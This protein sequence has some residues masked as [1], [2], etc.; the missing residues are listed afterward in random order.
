LKIPPLVMH[1]FKGIGPE[2][3]LIVNVPTELYRYVEPDEYRVPWDSPEI[4]YDWDRKN[5]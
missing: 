5:G 4:P 2:M 3:A 1:G